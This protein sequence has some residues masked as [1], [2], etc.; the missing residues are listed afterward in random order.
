[1]VAPFPDLYRDLATHP[2]VGENA[3]A[4]REI[5]SLK[6]VSTRRAVIEDLIAAPDMTLAQALAGQGE[7]KVSAPAKAG[8]TKHMDNA[9]SNIERLSLADQRSWA[10]TFVRAIKKEALREFAAV[11]ARR[12]EELGV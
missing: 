10:P 12:I 5:A 11:L 9:T 1:L 7:G 3:S 4:L 8:A 6:D 2:I